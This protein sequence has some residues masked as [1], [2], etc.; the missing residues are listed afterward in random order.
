MIWYKN[1]TP[2]QKKDFRKVIIVAVIG[3]MIVLLIP[4][5]FH[6]S[7]KGDTVESREA[8][9]DNAISGGND[10]TIVKEKEID[11][12]IV[13]CAYSTDGKSAI[14]VFKPASNG[15]YVLDRTGNTIEVNDENKESKL[16]IGVY[17]FRTTDGMLHVGDNEFSP[18]EKNGPAVVA[19]NS[20]TLLLQGHTEEANVNMAEEITKM[21]EAQRAYQ[22]ALKMIQT[23]DEIETTIN[24]LR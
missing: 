3:A 23:T 18:V 13:S 15:K 11:G 20:E 21:I 16:P 2:Q 10:W 19:E 9:L 1:M 5:F 6:S 22:F 17:R 8:L 12:Y 14:A 4:M 7:L 24:S